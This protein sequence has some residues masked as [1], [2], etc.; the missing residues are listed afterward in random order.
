MF[1]SDL[2]PDPDRCCCDCVCRKGSRLTIKKVFAQHA[3]TYTCV[4]TNVVGTSYGHV[5]VTVTE[6]T[7]TPPPPGNFHPDLALEPWPC[8]QNN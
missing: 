8:I 4:A 7:T 1:N 6:A 3:G 2:D 5:D